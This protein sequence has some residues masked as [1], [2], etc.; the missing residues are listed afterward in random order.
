MLEKASRGG[1]GSRAEIQFFA[2]GHSF[3]GSWMPTTV[4]PGVNLLQDPCG[5]CVRIRKGKSL[6]C[7][8]TSVY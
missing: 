5:V 6:S 4:S 8:L 7:C 1:G 3:V 2:L